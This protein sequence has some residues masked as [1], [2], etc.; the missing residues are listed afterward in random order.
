MLELLQVQCL[1][2]YSLLY[3]E[4]RKMCMYEKDWDEVRESVFVITLE[5]ITIWCLK[6]DHF[7]F[8]TECYVGEI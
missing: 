6:N 8:V 3:I 2:G 7:R 5:N 4:K 1:E